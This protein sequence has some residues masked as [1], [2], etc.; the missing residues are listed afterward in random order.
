M[1]SNLAVSKFIK[2]IWSSIKKSY[3]Q[4]LSL[5]NYL[6]CQ[7]KKSKKG[8]GA[9]LSLWK[10]RES[11]II[12]NEQTEQ[13]KLNPQVTFHYSSRQTPYLCPWLGLYLPQPPH[14]NLPSRPSF[15][16]ESFQIT[17]CRTGHFIC[18]KC[19]PHQM[20]NFRDLSAIL[21]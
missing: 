6:K 2:A 9:N 16:T 19:I 21:G 15:T 14:D 3:G 1:S 20:M 17:G 7:C 13:R 11:S 12:P 10:Q 4:K 5:C 8:G 18:L